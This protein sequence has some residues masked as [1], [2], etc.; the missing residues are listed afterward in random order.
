MISNLTNMVCIHDQNSID[1]YLKESPQ[2]SPEFFDGTIFCIN[3]EFTNPDNLNFYNFKYLNFNIQENKYQYLNKYIGKFS[4]LLFLFS[5]PD[6]LN[7]D[8]VFYRSC[9][10]HYKS[11]KEFKLIDDSVLTSGYLTQNRTAYDVYEQ[12]NDFL[13]IITPLYIDI[14]K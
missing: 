14:V 1:T 12:Y 4:G 7:T 9:G 8:Y 6:I 13:K 10:W 11:L 3:S 5:R 2:Y